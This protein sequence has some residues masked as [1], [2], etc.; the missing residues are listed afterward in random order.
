M[1]HPAERRRH[2]AA[3]TYDCPLPVMPPRQ[4]RE[5]VEELGAKYLSLALGY[6]EAVVDFGVLLELGRVHAVQ[7]PEVDGLR[8]LTLLLRDKLP[9]LAGHH[10]RDDEVNVLAQREGPLHPLLVGVV[11]RNPQLCL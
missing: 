4:V 11:S 3:A 7:E 6:V 1:P 8:E 2:L 9:T 10:L 5:E